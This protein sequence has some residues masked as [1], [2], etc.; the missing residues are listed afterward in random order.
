M[1]AKLI[2][3]RLRSECKGSKDNAMGACGTTPAASPSTRSVTDASPEPGEPLVPELLFHER[4][5]Y[6]DATPQT[7]PLKIRLFEDAA[8]V[9]SSGTGATLWDSSIVLTKYLFQECEISGKKVI[10]LG[11]G[12]GLPSIALALRGADVTATDREI[13]CGILQKNIDA[14]VHSHTQSCIEIVELTWSCDET[15]LFRERNDINAIDLVIGSDLIF[16]R[17]E[18]AWR[19]LACTYR[20]FLCTSPAAAGYLA[21]ENRDGRVIEEFANILSSL[22]VE[23]TRCVVPAA[24]DCPVDIVIYRLALLKE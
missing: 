17:N 10:E 6:I 1:N 15:K 20:H 7:D 8:G 2:L 5:V 18:D 14:N 12:L 3:S 19:A 9:S 22:G 21:Y 13:T 24:I 23:I 11:A 16:R 4:D